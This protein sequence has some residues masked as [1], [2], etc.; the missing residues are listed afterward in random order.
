MCH[1]APIVSSVFGI[2]VRRAVQIIGYVQLFW[3]IIAGIL[4]I[5]S[6]TQYD[7]D[8]SV[9]GPFVREVVV[10][11]LFNLI[12]AL[13]LVFGSHRNS[14]NTILIWLII[15]F[16]L[17]FYYFINVVFVSDWSTYNVS[18]SSIKFI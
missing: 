2:P 3:V 5:A 10:G 14:K 12:L 9:V 13:L 17:T 4:D 11:S 16:C 18:I 1:G 6:Y 7:T 15:I 8:I